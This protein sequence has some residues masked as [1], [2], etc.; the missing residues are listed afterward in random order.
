M[1]RSESCQIRRPCWRQ[2][3]WPAC[4]CRWRT[5]GTGTSWPRRRRRPRPRWRTSSRGWGCSSRT[6]IS[7]I[8][9]RTIKRA[10]LEL[11]LY[12][13]YSL[14]FKHSDWLKNLSSRP[15]CLKNRALVK[16]LW[17]KR[18]WVRMQR[19]LDTG[20]NTKYPIYTFIVM[21][22]LNSPNRPLFVYF[23]SF[24][25]TNIAK[26]WLWMIKA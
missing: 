2:C 9:K 23:H 21:F 18:S 6:L 16:W 8:S 1:P 15:K 7:A 26:I 3:A 25:M 11:V 24:R 17:Q 20:S 19:I 4:D 12:G 22:Y 5:R 13:F 14:N 10:A